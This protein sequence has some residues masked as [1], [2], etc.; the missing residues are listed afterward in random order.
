MLAISSL[1]LSESARTDPY[2]AMQ[3]D[4]ESLHAGKV[5]GC[6]KIF[7]YIIVITKIVKGF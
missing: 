7:T 2:L 1:L 3:Y 5:S 6:T 4:L